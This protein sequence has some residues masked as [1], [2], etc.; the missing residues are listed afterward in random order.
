MGYSISWL[1]FHG[2][3]KAEVLAETG[4]VDTGEPDEASESPISGAEFPN[5]WYILNFNQ[6]A[7]PST[8]AAALNRFSAK[9]VI[10]GCLIEEHV[11]ASSSFFYENG[12]RAWQVEH[13]S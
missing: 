3:T 1:A 9:A 10:I 13:D 4:L 6:Y 2:K 12:A 8:D 5:G 7:H 11:M